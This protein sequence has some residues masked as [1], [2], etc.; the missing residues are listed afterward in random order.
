MLVEIWVLSRGSHSFDST[1]TAR[2][3]KIPVNGTMLTALPNPSHTQYSF[4]HLSSELLWG[5]PLSRI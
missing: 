4:G 3:D 5:K 2:D 1:G